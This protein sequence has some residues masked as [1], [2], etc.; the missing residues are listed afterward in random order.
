MAYDSASSLVPPRNSRSGLSGL[1][2]SH[3]ASAARV[4]TVAN[5]YEIWTRIRA[6]FTARIVCLSK[7]LLSYEAR[8][9][10]V[11]HDANEPRITY[12]SHPLH[13]QL[14]RVAV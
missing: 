8:K 3:H 1:R 5:D 10:S 7:C 9:A 14:Y 12:T 6:S 13:V 2:I 4:D 11:R